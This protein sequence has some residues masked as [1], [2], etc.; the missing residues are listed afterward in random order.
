[1][2]R[3]FIDRPVFAWVIAIVVMLTGALA[4][5]TLPIEQYPRIAPPS[6]QIATLYPGASAQTLENSVTQVIEQKMNGLDHL[7]YMAST[8]DS[9][10]NVAI[11]LTFDPEANPDIAQ[12]QVQNKLQLAMPLLP[13]EVQQ[14]G[15]RVAKATKNFLLVVDN[16]KKMKDVLWFLDGVAKG[17]I[18]K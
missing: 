3:F 9:A 15:V 7:R 12:V 6:V 4:I 13:P 11:T 5:H 2:S 16:I 17:L 8:S 14:Q 18:V 1:M 10:G